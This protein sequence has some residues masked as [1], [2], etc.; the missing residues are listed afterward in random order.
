VSYGIGQA[1]K[2]GFRVFRLTNPDRIV[3]DVKHPAGTATTPAPEPAAVPSS[4][5]G[6]GT[7]TDTGTGGLA[8]TGPATDPVPLAILGGLLALA[9]LVVA[10]I[11]VHVARRPA[12]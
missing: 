1:S 12:D 9:G 2:A 7:D 11:G 5:S 8:E 6:A 3:L 10:G 4:G